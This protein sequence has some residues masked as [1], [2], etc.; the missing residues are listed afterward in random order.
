LPKNIHEMFGMETMG[1]NAHMRRFTTIV[2]AADRAAGDA[3]AAAAGV[4]CKCLTPVAGKPMIIRVL[5]ALNDATQIGDCILCG[6]PL[7]VVESSSAITGCLASPHIRWMANRA[8]P[9][10][11]T[12]NALNQLSGSAP[13][14]VTT[15]D[16]ALLGPEMIDYFCTSARDSGCDLVAAVAD[17]ETI[18]A[19]YP[20]M[21][22]TVTRLKDGAFC[23]CNL[24]A[25]MTPRARKAAD[26]WRRVEHQRK[27]PWRVVGALGPV[28]IM[29]YL[30]GLLTL[31]EAL[32]RMSRRLQLRIGV[33]KMPFAE[34]AVDVDKVSDWRFVEKIAAGQYV[35]SR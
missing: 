9:S 34:A 8:T 25:F 27:K 17:H 33:V 18:A 15:A 26:F 20:G 35:P 5:D 10:T 2:L 11:S 29:R 14:L 1:S 31:D 32:S 7:K 16:H 22:R 12:L 23:G 24:F 28:V 30:L 21:R 19:A 13:V 6:P 3:V 4:A